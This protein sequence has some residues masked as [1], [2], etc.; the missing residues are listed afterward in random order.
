MLP[1]ICQILD[2]RTEDQTPALTRMRKAFFDHFDRQG[3]DESAIV[4]VGDH[5]HR[6]LQFDGDRCKPSIV[7]VAENNPLLSTFVQLLGAAGL[8]DIFLC[9]GEHRKHGSC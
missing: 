2:F 7:D 3:Q 8:E 4:S 5:G 9:A 1:E 6:T